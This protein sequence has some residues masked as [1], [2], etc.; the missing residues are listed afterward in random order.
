MRVEGKT[1]FR[2]GL[3]Q[4]Q[5]LRV[6]DGDTIVFHLKGSVILLRLY[7]VDSPET[8]KKIEA[9]GIEAKMFTYRKLFNSSSV[10]IQSDG[11]LPEKGK[12]RW[13]GYVWYKDHN[14]TYQLLNAEL[15]KFGYAKLML[16]PNVTKYRDKLEEAALKAKKNKKHIYSEKC[17]EYGEIEKKLSI[18]YIRKHVKEI[19]Y[20]SYI[21]TEGV[22]SRFAADNFFL[23]EGMYIYNDTVDV[24]KYEIGDKISFKSQVSRNEF[25]GLE[26]INI[27]EIKILSRGNKALVVPVKNSLKLDK[28][29]GKVVSLENCKVFSKGI[30]NKNTKSF[31]FSV[32][33]KGEKINCKSLRG[34]K[35]TKSYGSF[36]V[37]KEYKLIGGVIMYKNFRN[38][39]MPWLILCNNNEDEI[40][41]SE[42]LK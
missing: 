13:L 11:D 26:L 6:I 37:K 4:V 27:S 14:D 24:S 30:D 31:S 3:E 42:C 39:T 2:D 40:S 7:G 36:M 33:H 16:F 20:G 9:Y 23:N 34:L 22:I 1:F 8:A 38:K 28:Y 32:I 12:Y 21:H 18:D 35:N 17:P 25:Y 19:T 41:K 15:L 10:I 5:L 29:V